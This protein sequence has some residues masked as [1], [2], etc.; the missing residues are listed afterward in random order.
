M[1][2]SRAIKTLGLAALLATGSP[3]AMAGDAGWYFGANIG[4]SKARIDNARITAG[5]LGG[6]F[7][8]ASIADHD[9]HLGYKVF[10]GY[11]FNPYVAI[12]GGYFDLGKLGF[13]A[14]TVPPGALRGD[15]KLR[16][17]N[18]DAVGILPFTGRFSAFGHAGLNYIQAHDTFSGTGA[19]NVLGPNSSKRKRAANYKFGFGLEYD[20]TKTFGVRAEGERYRIDDA[21]GNKGDVDLLSAG[22]VLRF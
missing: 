4:Q 19:V 5:L 8:T 3:S 1:K 7:T 17:L 15:I 9:R 18:L 6:G 13:T 21:V 2:L 16:G 11:Q 10:G 20:F 14:T 22:L 12:E